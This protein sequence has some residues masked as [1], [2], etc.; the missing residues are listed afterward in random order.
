MA[1]TPQPTFS[2]N[3]NPTPGTNRY[4][5]NRPHG[6]G[7]IANPET[8]DCLQ[9]ITLWATTFNNKDGAIL[10]AFTGS[11][12]PFARDDRGMDKLRNATDAAQYPAIDVNGISLESNRVVMFEALHAQGNVA[13]NG[14]R[15]A[16][17]YGYWNDKG[18]LIDIGAWTNDFEDGRFS[19]V[20]RTQP[21]F[22]KAASSIEASSDELQTYAA[23]PPQGREDDVVERRTRR[24]AT[25]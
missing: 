16:D 20:G 2:V 10:N 6:K 3:F 21:H 25:R 4:G 24:S 9:N 7:L 11:V 13:E 12:A 15:R 5:K 23:Q 17:I 22:E 14:K 18:K 8:P 1:S 19:A